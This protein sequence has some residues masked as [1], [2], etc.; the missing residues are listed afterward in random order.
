MRRL[1]IKSFQ[2][3]SRLLLILIALEIW[4][5]FFTSAY[6]MTSASWTTL[7]GAEI[8]SVPAISPWGRH[9]RSYANPSRRFGSLRGRAR[10]AHSNVDRRTPSVAEH[11]DV[12]SSGNSGARTLQQWRYTLAPH[13]NLIPPAADGPWSVRVRL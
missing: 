12:T 2:G 4:S 8:Y 7:E 6:G 11:H 1:S 13:Q 3:W 9:I 5:R 10:D